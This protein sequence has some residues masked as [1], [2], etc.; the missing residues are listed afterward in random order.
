[1]NLWKYK[2]NTITILNIFLKFTNLFMKKN[3]IKAFTLV[4]LLIVI[5]LISII[6]LTMSSLDFSSLSDKQK[7][8]IFASKVVSKIEEARNNALVWKEV[9]DK[10]PKRW[11][12]DIHSSTGSNNWAVE[13]YYLVWNSWNKFDEL[14]INTK[15][16]KIK[17]LKCWDSETSSTWIIIFEN[18]NS[19]F[20]WDCEPNTYKM[21]IEIK[22]NSQEFKVNF[23]TVNSLVSSEYKR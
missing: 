16:E 4:E 7:A 11:K 23:D 6:F 14:K 18:N 19:S 22:V 20:S 13:T 8:E 12:V 15:V 17:S 5:A 9:E 10:I 21:D 3:I 2:Y 1:M